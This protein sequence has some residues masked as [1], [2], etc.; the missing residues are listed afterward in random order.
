MHWVDRTVVHHG[1]PDE[2]SCICKGEHAMM[3]FLHCFNVCMVRA[4]IVLTY[5]SSSPTGQRMGGGVIENGTS[6]SLSEGLFGKSG[7]GMRS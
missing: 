5:R 3:Q 6:S 2:S 4:C 7:W 1:W